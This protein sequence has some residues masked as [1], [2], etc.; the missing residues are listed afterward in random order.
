MTPVG[1]RDRDREDLGQFFLEDESILQKIVDLAEIRPNEVVLEIGAGDGRMTRLLAEKAKKVIAVEIDKRFSSDLKKIAKNVEVVIQDA[2]KYLSA[3]SK[4]KLDIVIGNLPSTLVEPIFPKL[5]K[6][7]FRLAI[8]LVPEKFAY[9]LKSHSVL[10]TYFEIKLID[11]VAKKSFSPVPRT[12]WKIVL[13]EKAADPSKSDRPDLFLTRFVADHPKAKLK[14]SLMEG[15]IRWSAAQGKIIT[16]NES[17]ELV[18]GLKIEK[19]YLE[20][21]P[22]NLSILEKIIS[23]IF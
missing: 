17:R 20:S 3:D 15:M 21:V 14:N 6:V 1:V 5:I 13:L 16:K 18:A 10:G 2:L 23:G 8:F 19:K 4:I 22:K 7:N 12:N 11:K 9:K